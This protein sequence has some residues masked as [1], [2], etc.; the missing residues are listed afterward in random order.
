MSHPS[1]PQARVPAPRRRRR[2]PIEAVQALEDR[3]L[4]APVLATNTRTVELI[5]VPDIGKTPAGV[6]SGQPATIT[7]LSSFF[8]TTLFGALDPTG[9]PTMR[10]N[11]FALL[12]EVLADPAGYAQVRERAAVAGRG[13]DGE[14]DLDAFAR[15]VVE[16]TARRR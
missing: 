8:N 13:L 11:A 9:I 3:Q 10:V 15:T 16:L 4:L 7:A 2:H 1:R 12:N 6:A 14:A 5:N